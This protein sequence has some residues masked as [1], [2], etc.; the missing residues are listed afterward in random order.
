VDNGK[1]FCFQVAYTL[2]T[3][4]FK[5]VYSTLYKSAKKHLEN[6]IH[7]P[8]NLAAGKWTIAVIDLYE[9]GLHFGFKPQEMKMILKVNSIEIR[10]SSKVKGLFQSDYLY[11]IDKMPK[12]ICFPLKK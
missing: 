9:L 1:S 3:K 6:I 4:S 11:S 10:A 7:L 2:G 8:L 5:A 12:E